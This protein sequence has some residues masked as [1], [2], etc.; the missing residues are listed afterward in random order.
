MEE[1][2]ITEEGV[3]FTCP[4]CTNHLREDDTI[5]KIYTKV[6]ASEQMYN[7]DDI[8]QLVELWYCFWCGHYFRAYYRLEKITSLKE[9][10]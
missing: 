5:D 7:N 8:D 6:Q 9:V 1:N 10:G 2:G 3:V 4:N